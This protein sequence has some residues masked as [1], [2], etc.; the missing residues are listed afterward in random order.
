MNLK[1]F[2]LDAKN[3]EHHNLHMYLAV[4]SHGCSFHLTHR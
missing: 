4:E 1:G 2:G 3:A